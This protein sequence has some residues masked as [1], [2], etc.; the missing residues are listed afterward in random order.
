MDSQNYIYEYSY[1]STA[2]DASVMPY[3]IVF[4]TQSIIDDGSTFT[5]IFTSVYYNPIT[6]RWETFKYNLLPTG[7]FTTEKGYLSPDSSAS[8]GAYAEISKINTIN[9][10]SLYSPTG[11]VD[12]VI[13]A[14][15]S[16][17]SFKTINNESIV[18]TGNVQIDEGIPATFVNNIWVGTTAQLQANTL[19]DS[20]TLYIT[21]D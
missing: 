12:L 1:P 19:R 16:V 14:S 7:L 5:K 21:I 6:D 4:S 2:S 8:L 18:G 3:R 17:T 9:G 20:S 15:T 10:Q 11:S 13:D